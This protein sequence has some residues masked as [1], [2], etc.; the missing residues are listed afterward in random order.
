VAG[1]VLSVPFRDRD[2]LRGREYARDFVRAMRS[3]VELD[4]D[5]LQRLLWDL[6]PA[7]LPAFLAELQRVLSKT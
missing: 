2:K 3:G 5:E 1:R 7:Y 4:G 6:S